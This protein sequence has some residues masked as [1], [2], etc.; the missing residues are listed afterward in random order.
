[1]QN[2]HRPQSPFEHLDRLKLTFTH[3]KIWYLSSAGFLTDA[4]D[5]FVISVV[6]AVLSSY[7]IP[8]FAELHGPN[9]E[10]W[11]GILGSA[12]LFATIPGQL[13]FG[14]LGDRLGRKRMYGIEAAVLSLGAILSAISPNLLWL[15]VSRT[16]LGF[17]IGGDYPLSATIMSEYSN[18]KDRGKLV[19]L[20]FASQGI[21]I[22]ASIGVGLASVALLPPAL[23][24]RVMLGVGAIPAASV[25]YFRRR[26]PETPRYALLVKDD[27]G[28]AQKAAGLFGVELA[29][30]RAK[31]EPIGVGE[32]FKSYWKTLLATTLPWFLMDIA[33]YGTSVYQKDFINAI[34]G[35]AK[36]LFDE[37]L[38]MGV[39]FMVGVPGYFVAALLVDKWGRKPIQILG[40]AAMAALYL[41]V[42]FLIGTPSAL[43]IAAYSLVYFFINFGPNTT[44]FILPAELYPTRYRTTGH[45][46]SAAAG[47]V[48][49]AISTLYF[50]ILINEIGVP[51]LLQLLAAFSALGLVI[52]W[53]FLVEPKMTS[54]EAISGERISLVLT[55][56]P[57][58]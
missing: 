36:T 7:S 5:L 28:E 4:Y 50:P 39:P 21:G 20:V 10:F 51:A 16:F 2:I 57:A 1:M 11:T 45:G 47:K 23:A 22:L 32:F 40:F 52:S 38:H 15:I 35:P 44:T 43:A 53:L 14:R 56:P 8:G 27:V 54:L 24:W 13:S 6:L 37:I 19:A 42:S 46:I 49:A 55:A 25:I 9:A 58:Q 48:G 30:V 18:V 34:V 26:I 29:P 41:A 12:A 33:L 3:I 17:G 31:A